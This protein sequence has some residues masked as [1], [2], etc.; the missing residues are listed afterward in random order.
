MSG[1]KV[2]SPQKFINKNFIDQKLTLTETLEWIQNDLKIKQPI[3]QYLA[4]QFNVKLALRT[5]IPFASALIRGDWNSL[6][7]Q[8]LPLLKKSNSIYFYNPTIKA[9]Q[10]WIR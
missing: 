10:H 7:N 3:V 9:I 1:G 6:A 2:F 8:F 4:P 5:A